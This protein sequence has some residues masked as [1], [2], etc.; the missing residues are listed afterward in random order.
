MSECKEN[1]RAVFGQKL[2]RKYRKLLFVVTI[3]ERLK[4]KLKL[5]TKVETVKNFTL[6]KNLT[7]VGTSDT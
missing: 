3:S 7:R 6:T 4:L 2:V 1:G 5:K